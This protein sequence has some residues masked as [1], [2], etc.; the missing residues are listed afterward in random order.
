MLKIQDLV[1]FL[2]FLLAL[3]RKHNRFSAVICLVCL[4][5]SI[6]LFKLQI[7]YTAERLTWYA[8]GFILLS[9]TQLLYA[10]RH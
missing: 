3:W 10:Y 4:I 2:V 1:F 8:A 5:V 9:V 7:F 6:S